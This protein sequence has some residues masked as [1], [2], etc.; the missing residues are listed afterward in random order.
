MKG[1]AWTILVQYIGN[2]RDLLSTA[3]NNS[4]KTTDI[5]TNVKITLCTHNVS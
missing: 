3:L 2:W 4:R 1:F 5:C